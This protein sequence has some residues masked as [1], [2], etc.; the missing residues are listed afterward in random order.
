MAHAIDLLIDRRVLLDE[1]VR[2]GNVR[3][4]LVIIVIRNEIAHGAVREEFAELARQLRRQRLVV[5]DDERRALKPF[6]DVRHCERLAR[7]GHAQKH[8]ISLALLNAL[9][10]LL[11]RL[12]LIAPRLIRTFQVKHARTFFLFWFSY[13]STVSPASR[14]PEKT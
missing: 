14:R 11:N 7:A 13:Y 9:H 5:R 4:R 8:L 2:R 6:D 10:Q 12:R 3:L 1:R